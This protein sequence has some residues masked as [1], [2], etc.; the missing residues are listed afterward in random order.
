MFAKAAGRSP[1]QES[2][3][4]IFHAVSADLVRAQIK[5]IKFALSR[6][7]KSS[8]IPL[9]NVVMDAGLLLVHCG[10]RLYLPFREQ[11]G[12]I[13]V[14]SEQGIKFPHLVHASTIGLDRKAGETEKTV[15]I[16]EYN[17]ERGGA[18]CSCVK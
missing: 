14:L 7:K 10:G 2:S 9:R 13:G 8:L 5:I 16:Q 4:L 1:S 11:V 12:A 3:P 6:V 17:R 18:L 15:E